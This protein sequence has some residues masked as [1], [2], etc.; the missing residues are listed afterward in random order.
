MSYSRSVLSMLTVFTLW[1]C[2]AGDDTN[3]QTNACGADCN[4]QLSTP[5]CQDY[6][7]SLYSA[8]TM[9]CSDAC[10][11]DT[12]SCIPVDQSGE[13][14]TCNNFSPCQSEDLSC[15]ILDD[16]AST[17]KTCVRP[18]SEGDSCGDDTY[19]CLENPMT[20][21]DDAY[22]FK[23]DAGRDETC[24]TNGHYCSDFEQLCGQVITVSATSQIIT[25]RE[26]KVTCE[27]T[28]VGTQGSCP[29]DELCLPAPYNVQPELTSD[30]EYVSCTTPNTTDVCNGDEGYGCTQL[31]TGSSICAR[32]IYWCG[33]PMP[34]LLDYYTAEGIGALLTDTS[35]NCNVANA[36]QYCPGTLEDSTVQCLTMSLDVS[37]EDEDADIQTGSICVATCDP[38]D[39]AFDC[40]CMDSDEN[41]VACDSEGAIQLLCI[42]GA[43]KDPSTGT[44]IAVCAKPYT[45][46]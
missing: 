22:C 11:L 4:G 7:G 37:A 34:I 41:I 46:N 8:G 30:L 35:K 21:A 36:H 32:S 15:A 12:A 10:V 23:L 40:G 33:T 2:P 43:L 29:S 45:A 3:P 26:C 39:T 13:F 16:T 9:G 17:S 38:D 20:A 44:D 31:N 6:D 18:C 5:Y 1:A 19:A 25:S 28:E 14:A 42:P 24:V 27:Y